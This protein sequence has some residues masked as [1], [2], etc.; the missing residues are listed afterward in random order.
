VGDW[1]PGERVAKQ[2]PNRCGPHLSAKVVG[3][4]PIVDSQYGSVAEFN[5]HGYLEVAH[6]ERLNVTQAL[7]LDAWIRPASMPQGGGRIIDKSEVG[8]SNAFLLDTYPGNSLRMIVEAGAA[9]LNGQLPA[10]KWMHVAAVAAPD[11]KLSLYVDGKNVETLVGS[12]HS[13]ID[14]ASLIKRVAAIRAFHKRLAEAGLSETYE[15]AHARLAATCLATAHRRMQMIADGRWPL[16][17]AASQKAADLSYLET[18]GRLCDGL[19]KVV[20]SYANSD[21][22]QKR[23]IYRLWKP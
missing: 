16:L 12:S 17:P 7:S 20:K 4:V 23:R 5:G 3:D 6:D 2:V 14:E 11:G 9:S 8:T 21:D 15:A 19:E 1:L 22:P 13:V 10:D 18:A